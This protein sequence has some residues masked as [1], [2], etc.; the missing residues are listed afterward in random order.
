MNIKGTRRGCCCITFVVLSVLSAGSIGY[1]Q[2]QEGTQLSQAARRAEKLKIALR[3]QAIIR[4][5]EAMPAFVRAAIDSMPGTFDGSQIFFIT[6]LKTFSSI[7]ASVVVEIANPESCESGFVIFSHPDC[8]EKIRTRSVENLQKLQSLNA[9]VLDFRFPIFINGE[10]MGL[11]KN[12]SVDYD[13]GITYPVR[14]LRARLIHERFHALGE[15][16]ESVC[17]EQELKELQADQRHG[18][19]RQQ[20]Q[21]LDNL[22]KLRDRYKEKES[23]FE[24]QDVLN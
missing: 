19:I 5:G 9:F 3:D 18:L 15:T 10:D 24:K 21:Y 8:Q 4:T 23:K 7:V 14:L 13:R 16:R 22:S 6:D 20:Q 12:G 1:A 17:Y 11:I 2:T